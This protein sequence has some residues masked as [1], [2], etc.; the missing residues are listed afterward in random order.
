[1]EPVMNRSTA[2]ALLVFISL[3]AAA[4]YVLQRKPERGISRM[5]LSQIDTAVVDTIDIKGPQ[6]AHLL[7]DGKQWH[8]QSGRLADLDMVTH[9]L[10][11]VK[12]LASSDLLTQDAGR[13]ADLEVDE[14]HGHQVTLQAN[15]QTLAEFTLGK[16]LSGG[17]AVR[18][19][20]EVYKVSNLYNAFAHAQ[21]DWQQRRV[22]TQ[23]L[24]EVA[25][26]NVALRGQ[27]AYTLGLKESKWALLGPT[28]ASHAAMRFD[29]EAA[30]M[31]AMSL[32]N[33]RAQEIL[34][35]DPGVQVTGLDAAHSDA[36]TVYFKPP[37]APDGDTPLVPNLA[38]PGQAPAAAANAEAAAGA[39]PAALAAA[40][41]EAEAAVKP[42]ALTAA[43]ADASPASE[44]LLLGNNKDEHNV[45]AQRVGH[46]EIYVVTDGTALSLRK[47]WMDLR[48]LT[49]MQPV[50]VQ[51]VREITIKN[52]SQKLQLARAQA[53]SPWQMLA[54]DRLAKGFTLDPGKVAQ[55]IGLV[56]A[57]RALG[58]SSRA[59]AAKATFAAAQTSVQLR[60][61]D[62]R[63]VTL[64]FGGVAK[65]MAGA[66]Y[67]RGT[68][69][70]GVYLL[71]RGLRDTLL[72]LS[73]SFKKEADAD[74]LAGFSGSS[75]S[76]LPP[77]VRKS[78]EKQLSQQRLQQ[79][80]V[81][82]AGPKVATP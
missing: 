33:M 74:P 31:L 17:T 11:T 12:T 70:A 63:T 66:V 27:P 47:K 68:A 43:K 54:H 80:M 59:G 44:T 39:K 16:A 6:P 22:L 64:A 52:G 40:D 42:G 8:L 20:R 58:V 77:E 62:K 34:D 46:P 18:V 49:L 23:D 56:S 14:A 32:T 7:R 15:K 45:Y 1:M 4:A 60:L 9:A 37:A 82:G 3:G 72:G 48:D 51:A 28:Q 53:D 71:S 38:A 19:G 61:A 76:G 73:A 24:E 26:L 78:L 41:T 75:L 57:A 10:D 79:A 29:S 69:D 5:R 55:R 25:R 2:L 21:T 35:T 30:R 81:K 65:E 13:F 67:A 36:L 50:D